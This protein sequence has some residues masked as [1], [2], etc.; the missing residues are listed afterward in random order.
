MSFH[1]KYY[2][3]AILAIK[4]KNTVKAKQNTSVDGDNHQLEASAIFL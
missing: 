2:M 3:I 4:K 1:A